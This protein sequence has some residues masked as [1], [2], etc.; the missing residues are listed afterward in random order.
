MRTLLRTV[1]TTLDP[2]PQSARTED[3]G[4][5]KSFE[6]SDGVCCLSPGSRSTSACRKEEITS[7]EVRQ[8]LPLTRSYRSLAQIATPRHSSENEFVA[9]ANRIGPPSTRLPPPPPRAPDVADLRSRRQ[10]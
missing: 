10:R 4:L 3:R 1:K 9:S 8:S 5:R 6:C 7:Y 2:D